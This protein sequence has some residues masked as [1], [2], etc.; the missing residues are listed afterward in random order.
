MDN[1]KIIFNSITFFNY[2]FKYLFNRLKNQGGYMVAPAASS[3][4]EIRKKNLFS[5]TNV[6]KLCNF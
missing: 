4:S 1:K 2:N 3:L 6:F 5:I